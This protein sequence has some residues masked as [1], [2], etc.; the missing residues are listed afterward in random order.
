MKPRPAWLAV[1]S[2]SLAV[3]SSYPARAD[4][5]GPQPE[6]CPAG[7]D[8]SACHGGPYCYPAKCDTD[9]DCDS[10]ETCAE[11]PLCTEPFDCG[12]GWGG[13]SPSTNVLGPCGAGCAEGTCTPLKVCQKS[14]S[15]GSGGSGGAGGAGGGS[16]TGDDYAVKGCACSLEEAPTLGGLAALALLAGLSAFT[17][18]RKARREPR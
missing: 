18:R 14:T 11:T 1:C 9:T 15:T 5:V 4:V 6:T 12:G 13:S 17:G 3:L 2:F 7:S 8:P 16:S 10:G